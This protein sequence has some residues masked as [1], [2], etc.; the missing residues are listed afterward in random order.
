MGHMIDE[1]WSALVFFRFCENG[2]KHL[3][4]ACASQFLEVAQEWEIATVEID[5]AY[6]MIAAS[7]TLPY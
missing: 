7:K 1:K 4:E 6:N 3:T 5:S 2:G